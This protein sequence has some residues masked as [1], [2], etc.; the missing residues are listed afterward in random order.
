MPKLP[1]IKTRDDLDALV[2]GDPLILRDVAARLLEQRDTLDEFARWLVSMDDP[3][4]LDGMSERRTITL[5]R[6]IER[7]REA[8]G[9]VG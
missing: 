6:I 3:D 5:T 2:E 1:R 9:K 7:A 8:L 4:N